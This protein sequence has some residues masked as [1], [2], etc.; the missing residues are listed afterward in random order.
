MSRYGRSG[1]RKPTKSALLAPILIS[2]L[3][4]AAGIWY[5]LENY[6]AKSQKQ[7]VTKETAEQVGVTDK[8]PVAL[9]PGIGGGEV[10]SKDPEK[11]RPIPEIEQWPLSTSRQAVLPDLLASDLPVRQAAMNLSSALASWL[12][13]DQL[14][15]K[16]FF[17]VNDFSQGQ[18]IPSHM[19]FLRLQ[20]PF[21]VEQDGNELYIAPKNFQRYKLFTQAIAAINGHK[22]AVLYRHYRPLLLQVYSEMG[23]PKDITL[24][25]IITKAAGEIIAAPVSEERV[26]LIRPSVYY[27]FADP[28]MEALNPVQKQMLRMGAENT[29]VIQAKCREFLVELGKI[30]IN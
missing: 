23:Y 19:S 29:R 30:E 12:P 26:A 6:R 22:A 17:I 24:E 25:S 13:N 20:D 16:F 18:R 11:A 10:V 5:V 3:V 14:I 28:K 4:G 9:N 15:R 2:F 7:S 8:F 1:G 27:R 21:A